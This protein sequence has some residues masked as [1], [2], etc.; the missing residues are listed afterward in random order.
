[1]PVS[2]SHYAVLGNPITHSQSPYIHGEFAQATSQS[3]VYERIEVPLEHFAD[4]VYQFQANGGQGCNITVPFKEQ[5]WRL[6]TQC[7]EQA[8]RAGAVNTLLFQEDGTIYGDNTDG[9]GLLR[10]LEQNLGLALTDSR[11]LLL[12]A[13]GA[14]RGV[15]Q[16]LLNA[17]PE[18]LFIAN[19]TIERAQALVELFEPY[20]EA[21]VLQHG[22][23]KDISG[24]YG[25]VINATSASLQD[26]IPPL[27]ENC[28]SRETCCYDMVYGK[29]TA[30]MRWSTEHQAFQVIDGLGML[31]EQAADSFLLWRANFVKF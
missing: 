29:T 26:R 28:L 4:T 22:G 8:E 27:P 17:K 15:I 7:S 20:D 1:M 31:V 10:D 25:L 3:M 6:A 18:Q 12:G 24:Q 16:N 2:T 19:R 23:F 14:A 30:F 9:S 21:G 11:I 13:G 5:A